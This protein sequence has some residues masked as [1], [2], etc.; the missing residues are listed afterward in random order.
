MV[1]GAPGKQDAQRIARIGLARKRMD[2]VTVAATPLSL[3]VSLSVLEMIRCTE[4]AIHIHISHPSRTESCRI[5]RCHATDRV[6]LDGRAL[7]RL[8]K[9]EKVIAGALSL[10]LRV[11]NKRTHPWSWTSRGWWMGGEGGAHSQPGA[12]AGWDDIFCVFPPHFYIP[13]TWLTP[14]QHVGAQKIPWRETRVAIPPWSAYRL[15][16]VA[17]SAPLLSSQPPLATGFTERGSQKTHRRHTQAHTPGSPP[18]VN[19]TTSRSPLPL[20]LLRWV[21]DS[22]SRGS[23]RRLW[24]RDHHPFIVTIAGIISGFIVADNPR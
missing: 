22:N 21:R 24:P 18:V 23:A 1:T 9:D 6:P 2:S 3:S 13:C 12:V 10:S 17:P 7:T 14:S 5:F 11:D 20:L 4:Y 8:T 15:A 16:L 19:T